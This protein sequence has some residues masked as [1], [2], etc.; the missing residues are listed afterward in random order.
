M[1]RRISLALL[2]LSSLHAQFDSGQI[3]G[4]VR[5]ASQAIVSGA[6][7]LCVNEGTREQRQSATNQSGYYVFPNLP[8]GSYTISAEASGF[9]KTIQTQVGLSSAGKDKPHLTLTGGALSETGEGKNSTNPGAKETAQGRPPNETKQ[10][11]DP[12]P[13]RPN[14]T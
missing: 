6:T 10:N 11:Q 13:D 7:V 4:Y 2:A 8:V 9:K 3:S 12:T 1:L 14:P 5:D